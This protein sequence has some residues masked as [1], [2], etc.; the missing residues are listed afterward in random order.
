MLRISGCLA[1]CDLGLIDLL[2]L[3]LCCLVA[4]VAGFVV[5]EV[6]QEFAP[7]YE[8]LVIELLL[9]C[10]VFELTLFKVLINFNL[11]ENLI[12]R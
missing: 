8:L 6:G 1:V 3:A 2:G 7:R 12:Q 5:F 11:C 4:F 9:L 10:G